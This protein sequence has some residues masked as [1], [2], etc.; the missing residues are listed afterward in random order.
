M[1]SGETIK[2]VF[3]GAGNLATN[4][5]VALHEAGHSILQIYSRTQPSA[6]VLAKRVG[7]EAISDLK[8]LEPNADLYIVAI[9]DAALPKLDYSLFPT[10]ALV[11]HTAGSMP[12]DTLPLN[13]RGVFYPMQTFSR[14]RLVAFRDIPVFIEASSEEDTAFLNR[15]ALTI[16]DRV[17]RL[18]SLDRPYLHLA[19]VFCSNFVNHC[20]AMSEEILQQHGIPF[21]VMLP[22]IDEV[23]AK[24]HSLS[25]RDAQT[26]P[27]IRRDINVIQKHLGLLDTH[28]D[29]QMIYSILS[30]NIAHD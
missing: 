24:V 19:A 30:K 4:L 18:S 17:Y 9:S 27:A 26:G 6:D 28:P 3:V 10:S 12:M 15:L 13:R 14:N 1:G 29:L 2:I 21:S 5:C 8:G 20:Y 23:A 11:V 22:L 16:S 25:P 7:T